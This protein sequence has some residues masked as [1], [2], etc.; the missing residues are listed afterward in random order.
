MRT[1]DVFIG[2]LGT[3]VPEIMSVADAVEQGLL[4][5]KEAEEAGWLGVALAGETSAP[6]MAV[7]AT[8]QALE[9]WD[10]DPA[11]LGLLLYVDAYH[12]GP[13]GWLPQ[14]HVMRHA[15][16]GELLAV[17][18]RQGCNGVFG[19]LEL[20]AACLRAGQSEAALITTADNLNSP[21]VDRWQSSPGFLIG[22]GAAAALLT[23]TPGFARLLSVNSV[24]VPELE[25]V[26]RGTE[27]LFPSGVAAGRPL[28][29]KARQEE[30]RRSGEVPVDGWLRMMKAQEEVLARTLEEAGVEVG[31]LAKVAFCHG[32]R[33]IVEDRWMS[34]LG[35]PLER[36]DWEYG[37]RVGHLAASDQLTSLD[38]MVTSGQVGPGDRVLLGGLG[39]GVGIAAAV[40]EILEAPAWQD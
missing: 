20:A 10:G 27:P 31:D 24:A 9:R 1:S 32:S 18:V 26:H 3:C 38:H 19:A 34:Q 5:A 6:D 40:V 21:L 30:F 15:V 11:R 7:T 16:G 22:D 12:A 14:S 29:L 28:D 25:A 39:P 35:L 2:A 33:E 4:D 23:R 36:S 8:R 17:G 37:R 13:E